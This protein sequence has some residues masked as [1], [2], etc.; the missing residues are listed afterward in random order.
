[1]LVKDD[2]GITSELREGA[3]K[4]IS[5]VGRGINDGLELTKKLDEAKKLVEKGLPSPGLIT[6]GIA[7]RKLLEVKKTSAVSYAPISSGSSP[8][9]PLATRLGTS[10]VSTVVVGASLAKTVGGT[11]FDSGTYHLG[12]E[13]VPDHRGEYV[14]KSA[15]Y[16][17]SPGKGI[18]RLLN[19]PGELAS[20]V[21]EYGVGV[22]V[23]KDSVDYHNK[24]TNFE[25]RYFE[26]EPYKGMPALVPLDTRNGWYAATKQTLPAFGSIGAFES[27]GR[28]ASF[29]LCNVG[30]NGREQFEE[31]LGDD[32]CQ[33]IN[34]N[35][36]QPIGE[37]PGLSQSEAK[38]L[39][40]KGIRA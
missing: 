12:L 18:G 31:G 39:V 10:H 6:S 19:A 38:G 24:Y 35:T 23:S 14:V 7:S 15:F 32:I 28:V 22:I 27:S 3:D 4:E 2:A 37:F 30:E 36:G 9:S 26:R 17:P 16:D 1:M 21:N 11:S 8:H 40:N 20:F 13:E 34:L 33:L 29:W 25:V 5:V